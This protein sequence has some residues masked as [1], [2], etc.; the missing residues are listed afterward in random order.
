MVDKQIDMLSAAL[1]KNPKALGFAALDSKAAIPLLRRRRPRRSRC[2]RST[3]AS[4]ATSR[5]P[6]DHR[7]QGGGGAAAD[8]MAELIGKAG[9]VARRRA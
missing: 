2:S 3:R 6:R 5:R 1:A 4:T 9:E 7:Q 8:K